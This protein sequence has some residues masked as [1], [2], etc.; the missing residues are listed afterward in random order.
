[1]NHTSIACFSSPTSWALRGGKPQLIKKV[2]KRARFFSF[3]TMIDAS[4]K[5][6][7]DI[8][9][10][11]ELAA[12]FVQSARGIAVTVKQQT[13]GTELS[14]MC[15]AGSARLHF[16]SSCK[17]ARDVLQNLEMADTGRQRNHPSAVSQQRDSL[18]SPG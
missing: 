10:Q 7:H 14:A 11:K 6:G 16:S 17:S 2:T 5:P 18:P 12:G 1:M 4:P 3:C 8:L 13:L 15:K 9:L